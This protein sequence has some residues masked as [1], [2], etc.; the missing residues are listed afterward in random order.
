MTYF[1]CYQNMRKAKFC[2]HVNSS[3]FPIKALESVAVQQ[4]LSMVW[5]G[6]DLTEHLG[7][8]WTVEI[9]NK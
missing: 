5:F 2:S 7:H 4:S 9:T 3:C 1:V 6:R 8:A